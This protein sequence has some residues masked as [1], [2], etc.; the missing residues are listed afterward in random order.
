MSD[1]DQ[2]SIIAQLVAE[3]EA[4]RRALHDSPARELQIASTLHVLM[5]ELTRLG[6]NATARALNWA[7]WRYMKTV[8]P[9]YEHQ[10]YDRRPKQLV[11]APP[12]PPATIET[13]RLE[14][15]DEPL[16]RRGRPRKEASE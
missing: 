10:F 11:A 5:D 9:F 16:R 13:T 14:L 3:N 4:L 2:T 1:I 7:C 8:G 12:D 6:P 15:P